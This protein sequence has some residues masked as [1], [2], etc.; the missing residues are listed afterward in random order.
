MDHKIV[1]GRERYRSILLSKKNRTR[2][3]VTS[4]PRRITIGNSTTSKGFCKYCRPFLY[5]KLLH[6]NYL[7]K[8]LLCS[9]DEYNMP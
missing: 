8:D 6:K 3:R 5:N 2:G 7:Q 9:I 1:R 4:E